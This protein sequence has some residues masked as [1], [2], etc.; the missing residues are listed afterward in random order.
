MSE[1]KTILLAQVRRAGLA[2]AVLGL[3]V[4]AMPAMAGSGGNVMPSNAK[5]RD[6][7]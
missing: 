5:R 4:A 3:M 2:G 1:K 6:T 7:R